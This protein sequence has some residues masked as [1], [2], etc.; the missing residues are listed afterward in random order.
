MVIRKQRSYAFF[1]LCLMCFMIVSGFVS[2]QKKTA[3]K[4]KKI[5]ASLELIVLKLNELEEDEDHKPKPTFNP[6][7]RWY[8]IMRQVRDGILQRPSAVDTMYNWT[9]SMWDYLEAKKIKKY[10]DDEWIFPLKGYGPAAIGGFRGSGYIA[11]GFDFFDNNS[12][13]HPA[14]DIFIADSDQDGIDDITGKSVEILSMSGGI[15]VETRT[16]WTPDQTDIKGGNIV[17]VYDNYTNGLFY[18]AHMKKVLV[19]VG[20]LVKPGTTLGLVGRTGKNAYPSRSPTHLHLMYVRSHN[21]DL[22]SEDLFKDL[23]RVKVIN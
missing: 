9:N 20:D 23:L 6:A 10:S 13:G 4:K 8:P 22:V 12:G 16:D 14:H 15:V 17:Y 3:P 18:Y 2:A 5:N 19:K 11:G 7:F 21:G 1:V